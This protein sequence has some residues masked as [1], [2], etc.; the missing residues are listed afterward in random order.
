MI[1]KVAKALDLWIQSQNKT[2][3]IEGTLDSASAP[4]AWW[5]RPLQKEWNESETGVLRL[6]IRV[7]VNGFKKAGQPL[8]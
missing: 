5:G 8:V 3:K 2:R 6:A 7:A 1:R 4:S